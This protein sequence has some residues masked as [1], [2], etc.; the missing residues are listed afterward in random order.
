[1]RSTKVVGLWA[2]R[3]IALGNRQMAR[4]LGPRDRERVARQDKTTRAG[5][6]DKQA[7]ATEAAK[8]RV[9]EMKKTA[10]LASVICLAMVSA[11]A[12][13][14]T[15]KFDTN[16]SGSII[17][18]YVLTLTNGSGSK[19]LNLFCM[20]DFYDIQGGE[21]WG[22]SVV[23]GSMF[24]GSAQGTNGFLYEEEAYIYKQYNGS[25]AQDVNDALWTVFDPGTGNTDTNSPA[26][27]AAAFNF[28]SGSPSSSSS[29]LS[30]TTF[31]LWDG[32]AITNQWGNSPPQNFVGSS[33]VPEPSSLVLF[34]SGLVGLAGAVRRKFVRS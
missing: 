22:V 6:L 17:G 2:I 13:A 23:N 21:S 25:N 8:T 4:T 7:V 16:P 34:G 5:T 29:I 33:P 1:M 3:D 18:P 19:D 11:A 27:V 30:G 32:G 20:D 26:L 9:R 10:F 15:L 24:A 28:A 31:Y 12:K 14:D